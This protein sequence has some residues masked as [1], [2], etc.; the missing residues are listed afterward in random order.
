MSENTLNND[1]NQT[2]PTIIALMTAAA[3][4]LAGQIT[5]NTDAAN[6]FAQIV[7]PYVPPLLERR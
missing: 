2:D 5:H 6:Q 7:L 3:V 4:W 1:Q